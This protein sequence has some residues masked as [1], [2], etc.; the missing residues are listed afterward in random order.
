LRACDATAGSARRAVARSIAAS[1][2]RNLLVPS[3]ER[4]YR[5]GWPG[6]A[7][8]P[9]LTELPMVEHEILVQFSMVQKTYDG[10]TLVVKHLDL[11]IRR[12]EFLTFLGPSGS[13]KTTTLMML[14]GFEMP[15]YGDIMLRGRAINTMPPHKRNIGMV[16]QNYALFPHMTVEQN[17][18]FPLEVRKVAKAEAARRVKRALDMVRLADYGRRRPAQLS[19]GQQQRVALARA[20][21]F[22]PELVLMDEPLGALDKQ[23]REHMQIE[24]KHLH[25][26]LGIT[27]VYVTHDQS[28]ALTMSDRVAVFNDGLIQQID[29]PDVLYE[30]PRDSFVANFIGENNNL[31]GIVESV[32]GDRCIVRLGD[33]ARIAALHVKPIAPGLPTTLSIRPER[34]FIGE[35]PEA[36]TNRLRGTVVDTIYLGDHLRVGMHAAGNPGIMIKLPGKPDQTRPLPGDQLEL[37]FRAEDC[38]ALDP[39]WQPPA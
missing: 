38:R 20:L 30:Q 22:D 14:A 5:D 24:I 37:S 31:N 21:V 7:L 1:K 2:R 9:G 12:G 27:V 19:G 34:L 26:Q 35:A 29:T 33:G 23:L 28:E 8:T 3:S 13:G 36:A 4:H 32:D 11:D 16:F 15:T 10:E 25:E 39:L 17:V 18:A 6:R